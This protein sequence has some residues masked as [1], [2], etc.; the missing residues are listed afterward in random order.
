MTTN[1]VYTGDVIILRM[2]GAK[3]SQSQTHFTRKMDLYLKED[4]TATDIDSRVY[5]DNTNL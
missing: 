4:K 5:F 3:S 1:D 2:H